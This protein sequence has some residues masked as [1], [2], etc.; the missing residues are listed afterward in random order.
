M[1]EKWE[2]KTTENNVDTLNFKFE[3]HINKQGEAGWELIS[4]NILHRKWGV[5]SHFCIF[6]R[7]I[8]QG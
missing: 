7:K 2:Y 5:N 4:H 3:E 8:Q 6:R 1:E